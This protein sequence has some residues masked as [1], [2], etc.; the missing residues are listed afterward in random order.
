MGI[1]STVGTDFIAST[2]AQ[3]GKHDTILFHAASVVLSLQDEEKTNTEINFPNSSFFCFCLFFNSAF[4][5]FTKIVVMYGVVLNLTPKHLRVWT[6]LYICTH[7]GSWWSHS[8][9]AA[10]A[11]EAR[12]LSVFFWLLSAEHKQWVVVS[13]ELLMSLYWAD[14]SVWR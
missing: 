7:A 9:R 12:L 5:N 13:T 2:G 10:P 1:F 14:K 8:H 3:E 6:P 11:D 4:Y